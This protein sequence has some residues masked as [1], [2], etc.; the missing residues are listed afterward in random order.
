[1]RV[2]YVSAQA[3]HMTL[4][5]GVHHY[6][7]ANGG[8]HHYHRYALRLNQKMI[9]VHGESTSKSCILIQISLKF[10]AQ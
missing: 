8:P 9:V 1:M 10:Y 6:A 5:R 3:G 7:H 4:Q 2:V